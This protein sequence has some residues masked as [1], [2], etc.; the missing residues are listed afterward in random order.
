MTNIPNANS[1]AKQ[2]KDQYQE[3]I[4]ELQDKIIQQQGEI[5]ELQEQIKLLTH[6]K[7]YDC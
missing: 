1:L 6:P 5:L 7:Y 4:G 2:L 3:R